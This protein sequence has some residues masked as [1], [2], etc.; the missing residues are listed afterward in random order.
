MKIHNVGYF[1]YIGGNDSMDTANK[2]AIL[3]RE[4]GVEI[5]ATGVPKTTDNDIGDTEF[6]LIDHTPGY[7][8]IARHWAYTLQNANEENKALSPADP[9]LVM[10]TMGRKIGFTPAAVR[11]ADLERKMPLQIYLAE[12]NHNLKI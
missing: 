6:K 12:S 10:Q 2:V 8:S 9:V 3:A 7:G 4:Q 11:L 1:F 5:V